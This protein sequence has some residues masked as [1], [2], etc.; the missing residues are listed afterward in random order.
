MNVA[1][2]QDNSV[3]SD[4]HFWFRKC[5]NTKSILR[6]IPQ[7]FDVGHCWQR[8]Q[9]SSSEVPVSKTESPVLTLIDFGEKQINII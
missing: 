2:E 8:R 3:E 1:E 6:G 4:E 5:L 9:S 7:F